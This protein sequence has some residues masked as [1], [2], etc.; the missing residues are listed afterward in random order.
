MDRRTFLANAGLVATWAAVSIKVSGCSEDKGGTG[1]NPPDC[2]KNGTVSPAAGHTHPVDCVTQAELVAGN[3]VNLT[4]QSGSAGHTHSA[5][6]T[7]Q[8]VQNIAGGTQVAV[9]STSTSAHTHTV[10]F[11]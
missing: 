10:T 8:Q 7:A 11:N 6:L 4:L 3:Q 2:A 1:P 9:T 5:T